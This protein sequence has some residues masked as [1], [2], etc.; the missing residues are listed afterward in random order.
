LLRSNPVDLSGRHIFMTGGTG[1]LGKTLLDYLGESA[2]IYGQGFRVTVMSRAP[3]QFLRR[4][5]Q[6]DGIG[7]LTIRRG[8]L[9]NFPA[10]LDAITDV[11]HAAANTHDVP[12]KMLWIDQIVGGTRSALE[13]AVSCGAR[14]FLLT[15]SGAV[16]G[17][18]PRDMARIEESYSG[19]PPTT[20]ISS[21]YGQAKRLAEQLCTVYAAGHAMDVVI[22]RC[23]AFTGPHL[24]LHG[25]YAIGDFIRHAL[26]GNAIRVRG[27]GL[28]V[29]TYLYGRDMAHWLMT[30]LVLGNPGEAYNVGS[31]Q[32][33]TMAELAAA[34]TLIVSPEKQVVIENAVTDDGTRSIYVPDIAKARRLGLQVETPLTE[35]IRLSAEGACHR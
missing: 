9:A 34:V 23:F 22:A 25:P 15:S 29:R 24:P 1:F 6:Y 18:Q 17:P 28:A 8:D 14:R 21:V 11:I 20:A 19:A 10:P 2:S 4:S 12:D 33:V 13:W 35:A 27:D 30:L 16:Y 31:D 5:P 26:H 3:D 32:P 7:W